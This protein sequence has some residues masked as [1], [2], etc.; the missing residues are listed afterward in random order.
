[1]YMEK[2]VKDV[3]IVI[4]TLKN[5]NKCVDH[6]YLVSRLTIK[7]RSSRECDIDEG[8]DT[9]M[10]FKYGYM[11]VYICIQLIYNKDAYTI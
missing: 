6:S 5:S 2:K 10:N 7:P 1:M 3:G 8:R 11:C 9:K 4:R